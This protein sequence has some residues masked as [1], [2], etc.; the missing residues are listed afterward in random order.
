MRIVVAALLLPLT[1]A[2]TGTAQTTSTPTTT[3]AQTGLL[4]EPHVMD[5]AVAM[6][7]RLMGDGA[8]TPKDGLYPDLGNMVTGAG[9]IS[10]GPGYRRHL[11]NRH[12]LVDASTA[13]S[14]RAYK[15][16]QARFELT[17]LAANRL[18]VGSQVRWQDL[19]QVDYF[20]IGADSLEGARSGYRLKN[21]DVVGYGV[22][23]ANRWLEVNG[24][25]GRLQQPTLSAPTGPFQRSF[26]DALLTFAHDPGVL[27]PA[28][29]LHGDASVTA[30]TRDF[31]G[32]ATRGGLYRAA[33]A[34]YSDRDFGQF[35][36]RRYQAEGLQFIPMKGDTWIVAVR[37]WGV[38][39]DTSSGNMVPFYMLPSLGGEDTLRGYNDYRFHDRNLLLASAESRWA[40]FRDVD[41]AAFFDA[42]N[43]AARAG[44]LNLKK[45]S[46]GGGLRVHTRTSTLARL[47]IGHSQEGWQVFFR[48][49]DPFGLTKLSRRTAD[50]P[51]VP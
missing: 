34:A 1:A 10:A 27:Q 31:P 22:F 44:D 41:A 47:D 16:A 19:T 8:S 45:T 29:F 46:W 21:T 3:S 49:S 32:H 6:A 26:P 39:S 7:S 51:F 18:R 13:I 40:L 30:D 14:W 23:Q 5:S 38:F 43:V 24:R 15:M 35:S 20:G 4:S 9:W 50:V 42:G 36:F 37:G 2:A 12:A 48:L 25:F 28:S 33:V 17:D 11:F